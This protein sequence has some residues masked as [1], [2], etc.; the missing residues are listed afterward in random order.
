M[1]RLNAESRSGNVR[2]IH[3]TNTKPEIAVRSA[4]HRMGLRFRLH[5]KDLPGKPDIVLSRHRKVVLVHG[6]FWHQ[7]SKC[8]EGRMPGSRVEYWEPKL[9]AN[10][11]RDAKHLKALGQLGWTS[12]VVWECEI[13]DAVRLEAKLRKFFGLQR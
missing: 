2:M 6:C 4:M 7:H 9:A 3:S 5:K 8:R 1:D 13:K 12:L 11:E 10:I